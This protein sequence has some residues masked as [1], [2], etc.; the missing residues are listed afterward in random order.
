MNKLK[1]DVRDND[2]LA[3]LILS[4]RSVEKFSL[5]PER[6]IQCSYHDAQGVWENHNYNRELNY[7]ENLED[8]WRHHKERKLD[9]IYLP[10]ESPKE[11]HVICSDARVGRIFGKGGNIYSCSVAAIIGNQD[12]NNAHPVR[13]TA[14]HAFEHLGVKY[15][16]VTG[17]SNC[18]GIRAALEYLA[19][20]HGH[21]PLHPHLEAG[22]RPAFPML[23]QVINYAKRKSF[24]TKTGEELTPQICKLGEQVV[25]QMGGG[26]LMPFF[27][28]DK[29]DTYHLE[30]DT[31]KVHIVQPY[32]SIAAT[33]ANMDKLET[34]WNGTHR[35]Y[36]ATQIVTQR[37]MEDAA[38]ARQR[39][40]NLLSA[41]AAGHGNCG[42][43]SL[44]A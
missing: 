40:M 1:L 38:M 31:R 13:A 25:A 37:N 30:L 35:E 6:Q 7:V 24:L 26:S 8:M 12:D 19:H 22:L 4:S 23:Q 16:T 28:A 29:V 2:R 43:G 34:L 39:S 17:H 21:H 33:H 20:N 42:C 3:A 41:A 10:A 9:G 15:A 27:G 5:R 36:M 14:E 44:H 11:L 32:E 18:G